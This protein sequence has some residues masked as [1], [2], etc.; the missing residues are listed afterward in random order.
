MVARKKTG[1][2]LVIGAI[3]AFA[4]IISFLIGAG[5]SEAELIDAPIETPSA[6]LLTPPETLVASPTP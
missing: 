1:K 6:G 2:Y 4:V 3:I 5:L